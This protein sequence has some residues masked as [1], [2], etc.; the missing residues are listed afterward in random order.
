MPDPEAGVRIEGLGGR[1]PLQ[2]GSIPNMDAI[3]AAGIVGQTDNVPA[4]MASGS[5]V[6]TMSLFGYDPLSFHTGRAPLEAAAQGIELGENDWAIRCNLVT[7]EDG[8]MRSF[9][10]GQY[11]SESASAL[12]RLLQREHCLTAPGGEAAAGLASWLSAG[13]VGGRSPR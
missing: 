1:T 8:C 13:P 2:A 12:I 5:D 9:T 4:S 10:A 11:P 6:G 7:V 3:A